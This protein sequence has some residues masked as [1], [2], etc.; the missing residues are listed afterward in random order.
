MPCEQ[1]VA[2]YGI[3]DGH[4]GAGCA[5][6]ARDAL[7]EAVARRLRALRLEEGG[8]ARA[9]A[10]DAVGGALADAFVDVD[11]AWGAGAA[12]AAG[13]ASGAC[14]RRAGSRG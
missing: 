7:P 4:G 10:V 1:V 14:N 8:D 9:A 3:L 11:A 13:D 6:F 12:C 2:C 5:R